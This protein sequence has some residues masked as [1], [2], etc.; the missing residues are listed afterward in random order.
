MVG[1]LPPG[2]VGL[3]ETRSNYTARSAHGDR[4]RVQFETSVIRAT[5]QLTITSGMSL[6]RVDPAPHTDGSDRSTS[7]ASRKLR[8]ASIDNAGTWSDQLGSGNS[9]DVRR[10]PRRIHIRL[11]AIRPGRRSPPDVIGI[12]AQRRRPEV[13]LRPTWRSC[14]SGRQRNRDIS[15][16]TKTRSTT[17]TA[18]A[19]KNSQ[20]FKGSPPAKWS[21]HTSRSPAYPTALRS[22]SRHLRDKQTILFKANGQ[23]KL[24]R[25]NNACDQDLKIIA[26]RNGAYCD[27]DIGPQNRKSA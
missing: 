8:G 20:T 19:L 21:M 23:W 7:D 16:W 3:P 6:F 24:V 14:P 27:P 11:F 2:P 18:T 26:G 15:G 1:A 5:K 22:P 10:K 9:R 25:A 12:R 13:C 17:A 4:S